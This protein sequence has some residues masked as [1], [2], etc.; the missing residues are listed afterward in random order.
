MNRVVITGMGIY[1]CLGTNLAEVQEV[2]QQFAQQVENQLQKY[3]YQW[4]NFY[5][6]WATASTNLQTS[7]G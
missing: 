5:N 4:Y 2:A 7:N 6:F 1:S 3:P